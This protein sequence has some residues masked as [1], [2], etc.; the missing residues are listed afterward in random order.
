MTEKDYV[1]SFDSLRIAFTATDA[2]LNHSEMASMD[3]KVMLCQLKQFWSTYLDL[4]L[5]M[6][7]AVFI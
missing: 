7:M 5:N 2:I 4:L 1:I 6:G 3:D